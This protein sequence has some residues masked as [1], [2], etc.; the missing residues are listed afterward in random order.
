MALEGHTEA[1]S[2]ADIF[3]FISVNK[4]SGTL[5]VHLKERKP[6]LYFSSGEI[7][8]PLEEAHFSDPTVLIRSGLIQQEDLEHS[9]HFK[10]KTSA[11]VM[12]LLLSASLIDPSQARKVLSPYLEEEL[13]KIFLEENAHYTFWKD[14]F[15]ENFP[16]SEREKCFI[17]PGSSIVMEGSRRM[18]DIE[19]IEKAL[20]KGIYISTSQGEN[21]TDQEKRIG[22][23]LKGA[24]SLKEI[25]HHYSLD[26]YELY[27][28][29]EKL[30]G[31]KALQLVE[32]ASYPSHLQKLLQN[33]SPLEAFY[34]FSHILMEGNS[35]L[36]EQVSP[37][38]LGEKSIKNN[39][40]LHQTLGEKKV[41][42]EISGRK[43]LSFLF[44]G[45]KNRFPLSLLLTGPSG[46]EWSCYLNL[47]NKTFSY[48]E[49]GVSQFEK[50]I[51]FLV[52]RGELQGRDVQSWMGKKVDNPADTL[53]RE[54]LVP[55]KTALSFFEDR[56]ADLLAKIFQKEEII[57]SLFP[58]L[59]EVSSFETITQR[60]GFTS[61]ISS[62][63]QKIAHL[64]ETSSNVPKDRE[65]LLVTDQAKSRPSP[66][67]KIRDFVSSLGNTFRPFAEILSHL[68]GK[69][70]YPELFTL[71]AKNLENG[72]IRKLT[73]EETRRYLEKCFHEQKWEDMHQLLEGAESMG[74]LAQDTYCQKVKKDFHYLYSFVDSKSP[75]L[76]GE[77]ASFNLA[78]I[79]QTLVGSQLT[80]TLTIET[81][82]PQSQGIQTKDLY[83]LEGDVYTLREESSQKTEA[84]SLLIDTDTF[85]A[86]DDSFGNL[87]DSG[88]VSEEEISEE[89]AALVKEEIYEIF[90]WD[91]ATFCFRRDG[92]PRDFILPPDNATK[93]LLKTDEFLM[94]AISRLDLW[95]KVVQLIPSDKAIFYFLSPE[96]KQQALASGISPQVLYLIDGTHNV[97]DLVR[98]SNQKKFEVGKLLMKLYEY[99]Y[100]A[101]LPPEKVLDLA[102]EAL[103]RGDRKKARNYH[104]FLHKISP[105]DPR[106]SELT[107]KIKDTDNLS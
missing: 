41:S 50:I 66:D 79:L 35:Q 67:P 6:S 106:F 101:P 17:F 42:F 99:H 86:L 71:T 39:T 91:D 104:T 5:E 34:L 56:M 25:I 32:P 9:L 23:Y 49:K 103:K 4:Y 69:Y 75:R 1:Y 14:K 2:L 11:P 54:K 72:N 90:L 70:D 60:Y 95:Q 97:E 36:I 85:E 3:Q 40:I 80:G 94:E 77:L 84:A 26:K 58:N 33:K 51:R 27:T 105:D 29:L 74:H 43:F 8:I 22:S 83:F 20:G 24:M 88:M 68:A 10:G 45:V 31:K 15:P 7:W 13:Y 57:V 82:I 30:L 78:E 52:N 87:V 48:S 63:E 12:G 62:L 98:I 64:I 89:L 16:L 28:T 59:S 61:N 38:I 21:L 93:L 107:K 44:L 92:L 96:S 46:E 18:D 37:L 100:I 102:Q 73:V 76:R 55:K 19:R 47:E 65:I 53:V 81:P